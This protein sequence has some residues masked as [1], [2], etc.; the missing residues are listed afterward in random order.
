M[1]DPQVR[2][3]C[4]SAV[5][6][7]S[8]LGPDSLP[9]RRT[10]QVHLYP[11]FSGISPSDCQQ[12]VA[13]AIQ[14]E[15]SRREVIYQEGDS[16]N[17]VFLLTSGSAKITQVG[18]SGDEVILHLSGPGELVGKIG[19]ENRSR[20]CSMAQALGS[21]T[22]LVWEASAFES[23]CQRFP[24]L[25]RNAMDCISRRLEEMESRFREVSTEKVAVRLSNE[26]VR[27]LDQVGRR[28]NG[29]V[30][31]NLSR[32][33]LAQLI[34]TTL[35]TVSRLLSDWDERGIV[36]IGRETVSVSNVQGLK[37]LAETE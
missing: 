30:E 23:L 22:V 4:M 3:V 13:A 32:E 26:I 6:P 18:H 2:R 21:S 16:I 24:T 7:P 17:K 8:N 35:F 14:Q 31:I 34:G 11:L 19:F 20:H 27:L 29:A 33:E 36:S 37:Q 1:H 5:L 25:R 12:I 10:A 15:F 28:V 9:H